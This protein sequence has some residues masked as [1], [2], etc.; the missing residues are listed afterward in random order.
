LK[1]KIAPAY[2]VSPIVLLLWKA[3]LLHMLVISYER[4]KQDEL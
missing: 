2:V 4:G 1:G 3:S